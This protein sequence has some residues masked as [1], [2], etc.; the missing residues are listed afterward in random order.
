MSTSIYCDQVTAAT[1]YRFEVT[2]S[3]QGTRLFTTAVN[4]FS[5]A[6]LTGSS[7]YGATYS[8]RVALFIGGVWQDYGTAC[9]VTT[10]ANL[11]V[12]S[13]TG[14]SCGLVIPTNSWTTIYAAPV[15]D[16][17]GYRF[18]VTTTSPATSR[19][20]DRPAANFNLHQLVGGYLP[21]TV[22]NVRVAVLYNG[23][24]QAFG[25][26]C[27]VTT[28]AG[29]NKAAVADTTV[30]AVKA[31]PNPYADTFK[32][33]MDSSSQERVEVKVYDMIGKLVETRQVNVSE[34][35]TQEV[36]ARY[37]SGVYNIIVTQGENVKTLR[38]IKR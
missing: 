5:F 3:T 4:R 37:P 13:L 15:A 34:L 18:E 27:T 10:P 36:G 38:V 12:T 7:T 20:V 26:T 21:N 32:L 1:N 22:Y 16:A 31:Y 14:T 25:P 24:Y 23:I 6:N 11:A 29:I 17:A 19:F 33:A 2:G 28:G 35:A 30:F 8:V 9:N